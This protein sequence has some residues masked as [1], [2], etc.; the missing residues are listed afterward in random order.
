MQQDDDPMLF[1]VVLAL[2]NFCLLRI[3]FSAMWCH[4]SHSSKVIACIWF[5]FGLGVYFVSKLRVKLEKNYIL[6]KS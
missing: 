1:V 4:A 5:A 3:L 6:S 2:S